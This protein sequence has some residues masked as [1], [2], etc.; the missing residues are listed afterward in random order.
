M[1][2][3][4][5]TTPELIDKSFQETI[6]AVGLLY[7]SGLYGHMLVLLYS[8]IDSLGLLDAPP[9]QKSATGESF[10]SWVRK[11]IIVNPDI[12]YNEVDFW[13]ARCAVLHTFTSISDLSIKGKAK[14]ILYYTGPKDTPEAKT[15]VTKASHID[16][17]K[18][19]ASH[20][21]TTYLTYINALIPFKISLLEK[22]EE[23]NIYVERVD[24][25]LCRSAL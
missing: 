6:E 2:H 21:D 23:N 11:Y 5:M 10:K 24:N 19:I 9:T 12:E 25:M 15:L 20:L 7:K 14:E 17:G 1:V 4:E 22:C 16:A 3:I 18:C 8:S 13:A